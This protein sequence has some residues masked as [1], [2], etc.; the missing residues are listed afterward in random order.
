MHR[1]LIKQH[2]FSP[3][4][5]LKEALIRGAIWSF[6][7]LLY[8][9]LFVSFA[10][11]NEHWNLPIPPYL[12]TGVMAGTI[13]ALIYS[14][15]RLTVLMTVIIS[16]VSIFYIITAEQPLNL[17]FLLLVVTLIGAVI[18]AFY[19]IYSTGSRI[20][21]ADAKTLAG[22]SASFL[23]SLGFLILSSVIEI[24]SLYLV[25]ATMCPITGL[26]YVLMVPSFIKFYD[27][28]L[29]PVGDGLMVGV[30]ASGFIALSFFIMI[31]SVD[32]GIAGS[33]LTIVEKIHDTLPGAIL[34]GLI[35]GGLAGV[36][37]G[38]LLTDWQDL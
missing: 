36:V 35:G 29:P 25:V 37:S 15:M 8:A 9:L 17:P 18:G 11:F 23:T 21:R 20:H 2:T 5:R 26:L 16:P 19:G 24:N 12:F 28:L 33:L 31:S 7:G 3:V 14:S 22:F 6:I 27:N 32:S 4:I 10:A 30:G 1:S 38:L 13:G 34:G